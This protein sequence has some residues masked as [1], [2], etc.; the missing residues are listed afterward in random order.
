MILRQALMGYDSD[1]N[2]LDVDELAADPHADKD[3]D[4]VSILIDSLP[5]S[6]LWASY[7]GQP[8]GCTIQAGQ[9]EVDS[10]P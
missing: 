9:G 1:G 8:C 6:Y 3:E 4:E 7:P 10:H 5:I 2:Y